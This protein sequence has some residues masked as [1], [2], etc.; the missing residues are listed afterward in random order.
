M[1]LEKL[2]ELINERIVEW[3][4]I[5]IGTFAG[6]FIYLTSTT[7]PIKSRI[8]GGIQGALIAGVAS[9]PIWTYIGRNNLA[10]LILI[11][12]ILCISGQFLIEPL[13]KAIPKYLNKVLT[14]LETI[15][16][17]LFGGH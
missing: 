13:Q 11:T 9:Y 1:D 14:K 15:L 8:R 12:I 17:K 10:A 2:L 7:D 16:D 6:F 3:V 4:I 5:L